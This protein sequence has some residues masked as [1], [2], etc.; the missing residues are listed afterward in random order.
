MPG[1]GGEKLWRV[2]PLRHE[3]FGNVD[4]VR[5]DAVVTADLGPGAGGARVQEEVA[6]EAQQ[7]AGLFKVQQAGFS[8]SGV[9]QAED[10][11]AQGLA[12]A[13]HAVLPEREKPAAVA[14]HVGLVAPVEVFKSQLTMYKQGGTG[15]VCQILTDLP[16]KWIKVEMP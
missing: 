9:G 6:K 7:L 1:H 14:A 8:V 12:A 2:E 4:G 10:H 15:S 5:L 13:L 16:Y 3:F 11:G